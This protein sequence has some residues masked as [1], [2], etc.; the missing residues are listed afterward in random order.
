MLEEQSLIGA[1]VRHKSLGAG[2]VTDEKPRYVKVRFDHNNAEIKFAF[3][4]YLVFERAEL[5]R[6]ALDAVAEVNQKRQEE[7]ERRQD[8]QKE[9][10]YM[11]PVPTQTIRERKRTRKLPPRKNMAFSSIFAMAVLLTR[12]I[13]SGRTDW[14]E[15]RWN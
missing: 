1:R 6:E 15:K 5:L 8:E 4:K 9:R 7:E 11:Q 14:D 3:E 12:G 13:S 2:T 10:A